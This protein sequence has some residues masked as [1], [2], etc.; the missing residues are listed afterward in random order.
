VSEKF[1]KGVA[2]YEL[3]LTRTTETT[4]NKI[5]ISFPHLVPSTFILCKHPISCLQHSIS[6]TA[7]FKNRD[8]KFQNLD[9]VFLWW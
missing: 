5:Y 6:A 4:K 9:S 8:S 3:Q 7:K 2:Y 1:K